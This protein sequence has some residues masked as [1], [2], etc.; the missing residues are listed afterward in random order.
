MP[1]FGVNIL[2]LGFCCSYDDATIGRMSEI[3]V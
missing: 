1:S 2:E 3:L